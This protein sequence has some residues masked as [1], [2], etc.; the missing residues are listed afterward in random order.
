MTLLNQ[1]QIRDVNSFSMTSLLVSMEGSKQDSPKQVTKVYPQ[2]I[3]FGTNK[4]SMLTSLSQN[5]SKIEPAK[6]T[7]KSPVNNSA[8]SATWRSKVK[9][10]EE[11]ERDRVGKHTQYFQS[12]TILSIPEVTKSLKPRI[13]S[14][15][16]TNL[17]TKRTQRKNS[18]TFSR[19]MGS[20]VITFVDGV[21]QHGIL[22]PAEEQAKKLAEKIITIK[23]YKHQPK[24]M[25]ARQTKVTVC[26]ITI[27]LPEAMLASF[28]SAYRRIEDVSPL[29]ANSGATK[30]D[31]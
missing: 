20:H 19:P 6:R 9:D 22:L 25:G 3:P 31:L 21:I 4:P 27:N 26:N 1:A 29:R 11:N 2:F 12:N 8:P 13:L 24:Y 5:S 14:F 10:P 30:S 16:I 17:R 18:M 23:F 7:L 15:V 28:H